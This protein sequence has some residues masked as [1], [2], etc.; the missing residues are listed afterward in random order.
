MKFKSEAAMK[1]HPDF[2]VD[3]QVEPIA[4]QSSAR[5]SF[6]GSLGDVSGHVDEIPVR[7]AIPFLKRKSGNPVVASFGGMDFGLSPIK[8]K[9]EQA[10]IALDGVLGTKGIRGHAEGAVKCESELDLKG[11]LCGKKTAA[12][13]ISLDDDDCE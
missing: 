13:T 9:I 3:T 12:L 2:K 8:L 7:L 1:S 6:E 5:C 4:F 10:L 11:E